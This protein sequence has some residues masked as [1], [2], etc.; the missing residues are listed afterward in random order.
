[1][2]IFEILRLLSILILMNCPNPILLLGNERKRLLP[3]LEPQTRWWWWWWWND[4]DLDGG[5]SK[6]FYRD[7]YIYGICGFKREICFQEE[8][9]GLSGSCDFK[10]CKIDLTLFLPAFLVLNLLGGGQICPHLLKIG[11]NGWEVPKLS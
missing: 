4:F 1:M 6:K 8:D 10:L 11:Y 7:F 9:I 2:R 5:E 3:C